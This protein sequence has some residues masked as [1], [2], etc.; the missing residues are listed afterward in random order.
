VGDTTGCRKTAAGEP[1]PRRD[2]VTLANRLRS[3]RRRR[4]AIIDE[5]PRLTKVTK[6][7]K[8]S[9]FLNL[10]VALKS[11]SDLRPLIDHFGQKV[12]VLAH[13]EFERQFLLNLELADGEGTEDA[14][15]HTRQFLA[16]IEELPDA[17]RE[18]WDGCTSRTFSYGFEAGC[19][20][21]ALDTT[22]TADLLLRIARLG[23]DIG[24]TVYPYR[25]NGDS[26]GA[27]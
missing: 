19:D 21:P 11:N 22:I 16:L 6:V 12:F 27:K 7:A 4:A 20:Q 9:H 8:L 1:I 15:W 24:I 17:T 23:A 13:E 10:D 14:E 26:T 2:A 5:K 18:F 25:H 3:A